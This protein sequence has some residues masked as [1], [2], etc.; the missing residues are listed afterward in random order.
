MANPPSDKCTKDGKTLVHIK[1]FNNDQNGQNIIQGDK[2]IARVDIDRLN[3][4]GA[5][6]CIGR[7]T[8][9]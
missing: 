7:C 9:R 2:D 5:V 6:N 8:G 1:E 4:T 3:N